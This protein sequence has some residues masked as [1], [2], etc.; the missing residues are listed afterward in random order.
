[1]SQVAVAEP[2]ST[3]TRQ[4]QILRVATELFARDGYRA[5]GMRS[6]AEAVGIRTSSL[7]HHF[8]SKQDILHAIGLDVTK[9]FIEDHVP[10]LKGPGPRAERLATLLRA[11]ILYFA[12]HRLQQSVARREL[13]ELAPEHYA[14]VIEQERIYQERVQELI[15]EGV[16]NGEFEVE[17]PQLAALG[18]LDMINGIN[19]WY[20]KDGPLDIETLANRYIAMS[21]HLL[22]ARPP[23]HGGG[24]AAS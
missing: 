5:V 17:D 13:R 19:A 15:R 6:V 22:G 7:Y 2:N 20:R 8:S 1:M 11:H 18:L 4:E 14:E 10:L 21:L 23:R 24:G 9:D 12:K 3:P 16:E